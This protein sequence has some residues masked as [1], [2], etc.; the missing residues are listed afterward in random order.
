MVGSAVLAMAVSSEAMMTAM[1]VVSTTQRR[2]CAGRP[3]RI[4]E[5]AA[6]EAVED[7]AGADIGNPGADERADA[8]Q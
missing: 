4:S 3:S 1:E 5:A 8:T 6:G 2:R 7:R